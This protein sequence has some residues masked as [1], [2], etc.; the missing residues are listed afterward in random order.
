[1]QRAA[2]RASVSAQTL[3]QADDHPGSSPPA[4]V[5]YRRR[6]QALGAAPRACPAPRCSERRLALHV[7]NAGA[8]GAAQS[9]ASGQCRRCRCRCRQWQALR[10]RS[11]ALPAS[12]AAEGNGNQPAGPYKALE[13][14]TVDLSA[15]PGCNFFRVEVRRRPTEQSSLSDLWFYIAR[16]PCLPPRWVCV[17]LPL[18]AAG[19]RFAGPFCL[20]GP[21][22]TPPPPPPIQCSCA[23]Q[24]LIRPWRLQ[25]VVAQL[26]A[27]GIRGMTVTEARGAGMQGGEQPAVDGQGR[28]LTEGPG[29]EGLQAPAAAAS[30]QLRCCPCA[31]PS[32][33][34]LQPNA[35]R[36]AV[37]PVQGSFAAACQ[38]QHCSIDP[39]FNAL[40]RMP[41]PKPPRPHTPADANI[42]TL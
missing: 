33:A 20:V 3:S 18:V 23:H 31:A 8:P 13:S 36:G 28:A 38:R 39:V 21:T 7:C 30:R 42:P 24:A 2:R 1:L 16:F 40:R 10:P 35:V 6:A 25:K 5:R 9:A 19:G 34:R 4:H 22:Q 41:T 14:I 29:G 17:L 37:H 32:R 11:S 12:R 27:S 26:N 15:F